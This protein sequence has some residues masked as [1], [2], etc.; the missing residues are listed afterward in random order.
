M[1]TILFLIFFCQC[2]ITLSQFHNDGLQHDDK[3]IKLNKVKEFSPLLALRKPTLRR[4]CASGQQR[5][6]QVSAAVY[7]RSPY[8]PNL[9]I[10]AVG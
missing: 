7:F 4:C 5:S 6:R 2:K 10:A 8:F 9:R 1:K 3:Y